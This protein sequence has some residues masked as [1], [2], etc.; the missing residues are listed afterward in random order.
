MKRPHQEPTVFSTSVPG[1]NATDRLDVADKAACGD[2]ASTRLQ[3][4]QILVVEDCPDAQ[5]LCA[6]ILRLEGAE[7]FLECN[8]LAAVENV[9]ARQQLEKEFDTILMDLRMPL[10]DGGTA[11]KQLRA[12]GY[13]GIVV[14]V[15]SEADTLPAKWFAEAGFDELYGKPVGRERLVTS[16]MQLMERGRNRIA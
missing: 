2:P 3:G 1:R 7:V 6:T 12:N 13:K 10:M 5:R 15:T 9:K 8:G 14:A 11:V 4:K 16:L